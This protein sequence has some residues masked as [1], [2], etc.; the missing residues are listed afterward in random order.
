MKM[1]RL[2]DWA[3]ENFVAPTNKGFAW[4]LLLRRG[5]EKPEELPYY[6]CLAPAEAT[7]ADL[8]IAGGT[9]LE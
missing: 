1:P 3:G 5:I 8:V 7:L 9:T 4:L 6:L 2:S